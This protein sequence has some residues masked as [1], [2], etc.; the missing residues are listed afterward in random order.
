MES[1]STKSGPPTAESGLNL[2][3]GT[4]KRLLAIITNM[5]QLRNGEVSL[6][7]VFQNVN[8]F[9]LKRH[10]ECAG[11]SFEVID[12]AYLRGTTAAGPPI[13]GRDVIYY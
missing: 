7:L 13:K 12:E 10:S 6:L 1:F 11:E 5:R 9:V 3:S 2:T 4:P 8:V